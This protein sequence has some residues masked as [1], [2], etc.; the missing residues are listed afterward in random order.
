[1]ATNRPCPIKVDC[2]G[3]D[4]NPISNYSSEQ[5]DP[6]VFL[7]SDFGP[8]KNPPLGWDFGPT[9]SYNTCLS[10][11]SQAAADACAAAIS[12]PKVTQAWVPPS[13]QPNPNGP[14]FGNRA[15]NGVAFCPDGTPFYFAVPAKQFKAGS[16]Q[17]ADEAAQTWGNEQ[18]AIHQCCLSD[19]PSPVCQGIAL[20]LNITATSSFLAPPGVN[21]W[22]LEAGSTVPPGLA[23]SQTPTGPATISGTPTTPGDFAFTIS[24]TLPNGD[25]GLREYFMTVAGITNTL[26]DASVGTAYSQSLLTHG[27]S[28]PKFDLVGGSLPDGLTLNIF[29]NITGTPTTAQSTSATIRVEDTATGFTCNQTVTMNAT[30][31]DVLCCNCGAGAKIVGFNPALFT[32]NAAA[33]KNQTALTFSN[34]T[35]DA[36]CP[37]VSRWSFCVD[38][39]L[40]IPQLTGFVK[41]AGS[42]FAVDPGALACGGNSSAAMFQMTDQVNIFLDGNMYPFCYALGNSKIGCY[43]AAAPIEGTFDTYFHPYD[44]AYGNGAWDGKFTITDSFGN[45]SCATQFFPCNHLNGWGYFGIELDQTPNGPNF[46]WT[47]TIFGQPGVE[48]FGLGYTTMW[49]GQLINAPTQNGVYVQVGGQMT[50]P[51]SLTI[52]PN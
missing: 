19:L 4:G 51:A 32:F 37:A 7:G 47:F 44:L 49:Q 50:G 3:A 33:L 2:P 46:D 16:Q 10:P 15:L 42:W 14:V 38:Q 36:G 28:N 22:A 9:T 52:G 31:T 29:G 21:V 5:P 45:G 43:N 25:V 6:V 8:N 23:L 39:N 20:S 18:A 35:P 1:M 26:P 17:A 12:G 48:G 30:Q 11:V 13:Q 27:F 24:V 40:T 34:I 41:V